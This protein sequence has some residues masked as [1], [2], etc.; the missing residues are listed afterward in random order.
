M[1][2][3]LHVLA[4]T[5]VTRRSAVLRAAAGAA[6]LFYRAA[7]V[8]AAPPAAAPAAVRVPTFAL[9]SLTASRLIQGHWQLAGGHGR[10]TVEGALVNM[11]AHY[12]A[13][14]TTLD[15]ADIYGPSELIVGE[16]VKRE[17][18][19]VP[20][21]KFCCFRGLQSI[22]KAEVRAR[23]VAQCERLNVPSLPLVQFFWADYGVQRYVQVAQML[24]ALKD[25]GLIQN[26]GLTNFDLPRVRQIV[27]AGV[28]IVSQQV[29]LSALDS[30]PLQSGMAEYCAQQRI[31]LLAFGTVGAGLLS[32]RFVGA[33]PPGAEAVRAG[34]SSLSMY[35]ATAS[36]FGPWSL[37]QELLH[38]MADVARAHPGASVANVAQ[39]YALQCSPAV[40]AL[41]VG[42][43]NSEH[44]AENAR[45]FSFALSDGEMDA[46]RAVVAKRQGPR[47][48]VWD[49]ERGV[50][51]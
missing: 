45:T 38:T 36:R 17:P 12:D 6:P 39:R 32:D 40:G 4:L 22:D 30:R 27:E 1:R 11:R 15:T 9:G 35:S 2:A 31:S 44:V 5:T 29:Q 37:V 8:P 47:G 33:P 48:D 18:R 46:I 34:G 13:G 26:I 3:L 20:C 16:F 23:V 49:L 24:G 28:P 25:E 41:I 51:V 50:P 10:Y 14:L 43:R 42:V 19:A 7:P 21:T